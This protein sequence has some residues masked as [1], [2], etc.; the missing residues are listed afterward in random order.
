MTDH[1]DPR[2][3]L[4]QP[5]ARSGFWLFALTFVL[6]V[7]ITVV[8]VAVSASRSG[9]AGLAD[10]LALGGVILLCGVLWQVLSRFMR[11]QAL[12]LSAE[13]LEVRSSFYRSRTLLSELKLDQ[14]RVVDL[15][16][17]IELRPMLK[18]N[19]FA[20]PG[21]HSG[22]FLLRNR[23]RAFVA[24]ADGRR[25]LW[26]PAHGKHDLLLEPKDPGALLARLRELAT[27]AGRG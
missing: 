2:L 11:R 15:D 7:A 27:P 6:P 18:T 22:W 19:G 23:R 4:A 1:T 10:Y 14:A 12:S 13:A 25:K 20:L 8:A 24:T 17:H 9:G 3:Q 5:G 26:L 21:F 16:E